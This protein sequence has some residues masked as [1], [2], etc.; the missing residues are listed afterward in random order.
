MVLDEFH[1]CSVTNPTDCVPTT[2]HHIL[3]ERQLTFE[4]KPGRRYSFVLVEGLD[5]K[6]LKVEKTN[7]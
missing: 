3:P 7:G 1:D 6:P 2:K 4:K 5:K